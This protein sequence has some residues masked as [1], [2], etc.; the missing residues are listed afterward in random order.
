VIVEQRTNAW[1]VR[2]LLNS[3]CHSVERI[4]LVSVSLVRGI[5]VEES[6]YL[7]LSTRASPIRTH[8][9]E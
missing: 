2:K 5:A 1:P 4:S 6:G 7:Y 8:S 9:K 3:N